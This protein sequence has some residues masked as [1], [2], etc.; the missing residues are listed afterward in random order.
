MYHKFTRASGIYRVPMREEPD[1]DS[2]NYFNGAIIFGEYSIMEEDQEP[3]TL[4]NP[5]L[6]IHL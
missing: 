5:M 4:Q 3:H 1:E 2:S 6:Q